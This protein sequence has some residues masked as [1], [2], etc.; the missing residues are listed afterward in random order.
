MTKTVSQDYSVIIGTIAG[1]L[2]YA[3]ESKNTFDPVLVVHEIRM[4]IHVRR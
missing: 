1:L 2:T 4:T 3:L